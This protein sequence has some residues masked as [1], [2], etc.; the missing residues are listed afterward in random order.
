MRALAT[1]RLMLEPQVVSHAED[2]FRVLSDPAIYAYE[3]EPPA[4]EE[5]LRERF[6]KLETRLS[7]DG[8]EDWLNW[9]VRLRSGELIG[10][11]QASVERRGR[12]GIAY[13][14]ASRH[15]GQGFAREAVRAMMDELA[16]N[17][18][19]RE[20][21]AVLKRPNE[22]SRRLLERVG[23]TPWPADAADPPAIEPDELLMRLPGC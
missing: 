8:S 14:L 10:Y 23:F 5:W 3:N 6:R 12:A 17:Y 11:V 13:V 19:V 2:M 18:G 21:T 16:A 22:R 9:V 1:R 20:F 7:G 4:S 15:W